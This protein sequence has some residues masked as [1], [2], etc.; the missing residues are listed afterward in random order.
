VRQIADL[1]H[2][3]KGSA[4]IIGAGRAKDLA[5]SLE[6]FARKREVDTLQ[7]CFFRMRQ[8]YCLVLDTVRGFL[9]NPDFG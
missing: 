8:E 4:A 9:E 5:S 1:A 7:E 2:T 3:I 6:Q